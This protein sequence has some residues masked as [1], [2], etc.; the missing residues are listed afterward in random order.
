[1]SQQA[2]VQERGKTATRDVAREGGKGAEVSEAEVTVDK[3]AGKTDHADNEIARAK[4][5]T[6]EEEVEVSDDAAGDDKA[7]DAGKTD[8]AESEIAR[9]KDETQEVRGGA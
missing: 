3:D 2:L 5:E 1:M 7:K 4:D 6:Q 9:A 8:H